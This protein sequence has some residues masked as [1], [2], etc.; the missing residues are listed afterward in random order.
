MIE[1]GNALVS[2]N[3]HQISLLIEG[4]AVFFNSERT[5]SGSLYPTSALAARGWN[6]LLDSA[7]STKR[8]S[9]LLLTV[10]IA[11]D[12]HFNETS[13][14]RTSTDILNVYC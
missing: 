5:A 14:S 10:R 9:D 4:F 6:V 2:N 11:L 8:L 7:T 12:R 3:Y 1:A 13:R